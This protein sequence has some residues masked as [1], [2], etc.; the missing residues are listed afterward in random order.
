M[1]KPRLVSLFTGAG[2]LDLGLEDA[3]FETIFANEIEGPACESLRSNR[4]L[5]R[6]SLPDFDVWFDSHVMSQRCNAKISEV[7]RIRLR[8]RLLAAIRTNEHY[9]SDTVIVQRDIRDLTS[10]EIMTSAGVNPGEL[11]LVAGGPPCQPFSRAGKREMVE[12]TDG[13]LFLDFVR[14]V[15]DLKPRWFLFENVKG[16]VVQKA[17]V[18]R[19]TCPACNGSKISRFAERDLL[20]EAT[21]HSSFCN[22]CDSQEDHIV[23]WD[24]VRGGSLDVIMN[25]FASI[26]Y[27]CQHTVLNAADFG[28]AQSRERLI[29]I[30]SRD[31]EPIKW[32]EPTHESVSQK[33]KSSPT[34]FDKIGRKPSYV[35]VREALYTEGHWRYG[36]LPAKSAV[37]WVKNVVRPHDEPV[38]F[39]LDG[40]A[41]TIGAHQAA[42]LAIA[43]TGV[44]EAQLKRQQWHTLGKRQGDTPPVF[45][46]HEYFTDEE[47]LLLQTFPRSW[48]LH[49]TRME[50]AFQIGNAVP[51]VLA[52]AVGKAIMNALNVELPRGERRTM[53]NEMD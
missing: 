47:L 22:S 17:D 13:Q 26:G 4:T 21:L 9:L 40:L 38:T 7:E 10:Q 6:L 34:L 51:P 19:L 39:S 32:P 41:P 3:G 27:S 46:E 52:H 20:K 35:S 33:S 11:D 53:V 44:P 31:G 2:G 29:L 42:K 48:Y 5:R 43:P 23:S 36:E 14:I 1:A 37:I 50:R 15:N 25:E 12:S 28:A 30:G 18:A 8:T 16:L 49:G 24:K 45:V